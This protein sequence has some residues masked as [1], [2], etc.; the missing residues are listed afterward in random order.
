MVYFFII[1][2]IF[3]KLLESVLLTKPRYGFNN[4]Y[5]NYF[6]P[7]KDEKHEIIKLIEPDK[8]SI[9]GINNKYYL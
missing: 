2:I 6:E 4:Q 3:D 7:L 5:F 1:Y 8:M 9:L